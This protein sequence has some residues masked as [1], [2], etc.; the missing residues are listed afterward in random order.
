MQGKTVMSD[1][2]KFCHKIKFDSNRL[3]QKQSE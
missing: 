1:Q 2:H 3:I